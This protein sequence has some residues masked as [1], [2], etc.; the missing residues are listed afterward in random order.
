[1]R[2]ARKIQAAEIADLVLNTLMTEFRERCLPLISSNDG[3]ISYVSEYETTKNEIRRKWYDFCND[4]NSRER[5]KKMGLSANLN[6]FES[7]KDMAIRGYSE[8]VFIE[9]IRV[10]LQQYGLENDH[11]PEEFISHLGKPAN[12]VIIN[13]IIESI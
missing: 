10:R 3:I 13:F 1:M 11:A 7:A 8:Y 9:A 12:D 4:F 2:K 5:I 6:M